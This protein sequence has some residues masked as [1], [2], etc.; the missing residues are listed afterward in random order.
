MRNNLNN[1]TD[2]AMFSLQFLTCYDE[3]DCV[4]SSR[5]LQAFF[6]TFYIEVNYLARKVDFSL[7]ENNPSRFYTENLITTQLKVM[8]N[9]GGIISL[10]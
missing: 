3:P 4:T 6:N 8:E 9:Q 7:Y 5:D 10:M 1:L 2:K